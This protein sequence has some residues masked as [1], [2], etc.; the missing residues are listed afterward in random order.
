MHFMSDNLQKWHSKILK[1]TFYPTF[2]FDNLQKSDNLYLRSI[3]MKIIGRKKELETLNRLLNS[4]RPEFVCL[5]GRR[6]VGKTFLIKQ[7]F[8]EKFSFYTTGI[9]K[10]SNR[11]QLSNF[12]KKLNEYGYKVKGSVTSWID[13]FDDLIELLKKDDVYRINGKRVV[14]ID[15]VPWMDAPKSDF[16]AGLDNF[17]NSWGSSQADLILIVC[18]SATSWIINNLLKDTGGFYNRVT[19]KIKL[20]PFNIRELEELLLYNN[21]HFSTREIIETYMIFGGIPFYIN[22]LNENLSL[23]QN[24]DELFFKEDSELK[25]EKDILLSSLF[26]HHE[27]H[28][29]ILNVLYR[30]KS[31][32]S[33]KEISDLVPID[34]GRTINTALTE[35]EECG[36]IRKFFDYKGTKRDSL[37]QVIDPFVLFSFNIS[38]QNI[39]S[40]NDYVGTPKY[41]A[42]SG[43][44]FEIFCLNHIFEIK[45]SLGISGISTNEYSFIK[46]ESSYGAQIDLLI[47]RK[48]YTI[49][50]CEM[51]FCNSEYE[52]TK[53]DEQSILNKIDVFKKVTKSK[54]NIKTTFITLYGIKNNTHSHI[55]D[56]NV[57]VSNWFNQ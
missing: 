3:C 2:L 14:F 19:K 55:V 56:K 37:Y 43:L 34:D 21:V 54:K 41:Y 5:Y 24:V 17:W 51:K 29:A 15:E 53:D 52:I 16:K 46:K 18:G 7:F 44:S 13:A 47:D 39:S 45:K 57:V 36:F 11:S 49:N 12:K 42:W 33:H 28:E 48:D 31:G 25:N 1:N 10:L 26:K 6:R 9:K 30:K 8:R 38:E 50:L 4:P 22:L 40:W 32:L 35:L 23:A 27:N 20:C